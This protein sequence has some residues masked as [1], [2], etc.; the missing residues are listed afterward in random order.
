MTDLAW[1]IVVLIGLVM[2]DKRLGQYL[3]PPL[4]DELMAV[5]DELAKQKTDNNETRNKVNTLMLDK[6]F[7]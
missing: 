3:N 6:G 2:V 1:P 5:K 7:K 4:K